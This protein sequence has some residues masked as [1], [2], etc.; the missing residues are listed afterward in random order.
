MLKLPSYSFLDAGLC[1]FIIVLLFVTGAGCWQEAVSQ[2][3]EEEIY[4][5]NGMPWWGQWGYTDYCPPDSIGNSSFAYA[6][7]FKVSLAKLRVKVC[8]WGG[9]G[10]CRCFILTMEDVRVFVSILPLFAIRLHVLIIFYFSCV[11]RALRSL[12]LLP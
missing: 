3:Y 10:G 11:H 5:D 7:D 6:L 8:V 9:R 4:V 2:Y 12:C 1:R